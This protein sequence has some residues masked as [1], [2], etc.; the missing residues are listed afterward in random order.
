M[1]KLTIR[2]A[3]TFFIVFLPLAHTQCS[4]HTK[5][6]VCPRIRVLIDSFP[7][8]KPQTLSLTSERGMHLQLPPRLKKNRTKHFFQNTLFVRIH[9]NAIW[10]AGSK[11]IFRKIKA[12]HLT[13]IPRTG[14]TGYQDKVFKGTFRIVLNRKTKQVMVINHIPIEDYLYSVLRYEVFQSW[15]LEMHKVQAIASR[16]YAFNHLFRAKNNQW[17]DVKRTNTHQ[18]YQGHHPY[19]HLYQAIEQ[20]RGMI[21]KHKGHVIIAM[22]DACCGGT[23]P[24]DIAHHNFQ[25]APYLARKWACTFCQECRLY[26]WEKRI[27]KTNFLDLLKHDGHPHRHLTALGVLKHAQVHATD[28]AGIITN[29]RLNGV[30]KHI[31]LEGKQLHA[32]LTRIVRSLR[33]SIDSDQDDLILHGYGYGHLTGLCQYGARELVRRKWHYSSILRFYYP[34]T[35]LIKLRYA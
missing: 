21:L 25:T 26:S 27:P 13:L 8:Q 17:Y 14:M 15:P 5:K 22:F 34:E 23:I 20:T 30:K 19:T 24:A 31:H 12:D 29:L 33:F 35:E 16:S 11:R 6:P 2:V 1:E 9:D 3:L 32:T 18:S 4:S 10:L 7:M 28:K